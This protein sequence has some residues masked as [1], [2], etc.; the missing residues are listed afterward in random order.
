MVVVLACVLTEFQVTIM[1]GLSNAKLKLK[2]KIRK[3]VFSQ[4]DKRYFD[5][6]H[7][8]GKPIER[9]GNPVKKR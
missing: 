1:R 3:I 2:T 6:P 7:R 8:M 9:E 5:R 4:L